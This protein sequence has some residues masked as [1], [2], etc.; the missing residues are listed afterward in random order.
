M[1]GACRSV[2]RELLIE[3]IAG[4]HTGSIHGESMMNVIF[5][6][7][8]VTLAAGALLIGGPALAQDSM[9]D[10]RTVERVER[11]RP[12]VRDVKDQRRVVDADYKAMVKEADA[13]YKRAAARCKDLKGNEKDVCVKEAKATRKKAKAEA[14]AKRDSARAELKAQ[15]T[16]ARDKDPEDRREARREASE[17]KREARRN[18]NEQA[19]EADYKVAR[20]RCES[21]KGNAKD[22]CMAQAKQR[23]EKDRPR[24]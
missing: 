21:L 7:A 19:R 12:A 3:G 23:F 4:Q 13:G 16:I 14:K 18:A 5:K 9:K 24:G 15:R 2:A 22:A 11:D 17:D 6:Q 1:H 10:R 20:E 8:A